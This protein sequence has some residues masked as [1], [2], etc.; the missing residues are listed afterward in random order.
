[1]VRKGWSQLEVP[2][3]WIQLTSTSGGKGS[4]PTEAECTR[5]EDVRYA[6][7]PR[8]ISEGDRSTGTG[9]QVG[10]CFGSFAWCGGAGSRQSSSRFETDQG[11]EVDTIG[12]AL[13]RARAHLTELDAKRAVVG[14][15]LETSPH[16]A[17]NAVASPL[18]VEA[19]CPNQ[20]SGRGSSRFL[21]VIGSV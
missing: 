3:G 9:G 18:Q 10:V 19:K 15:W 14:T 11:R 21:E 17:E 16:V 13:V 1:M 4:S 5:C 7:V 8:S 12:R 6:P 2:N 20:S